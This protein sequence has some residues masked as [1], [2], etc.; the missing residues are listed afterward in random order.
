MK[1]QP[2][3][4]ITTAL[5]AAMT[6]IAVPQAAFAASAAEL[7][8]WRSAERSGDV[9]DYRAYLRQYPDGDFVDLARNRIDAAEAAA[10]TRAPA[11]QSSHSTDSAA[12]V[13]DDL[14]LTYKDKTRIQTELNALGYDT[15]G[16]D[17]IFGPGTRGSIRGWQS[18]IGQTPTGYLT[19]AQAD[20]LLDAADEREFT[21]SGQAD[22]AAQ[23]AARRGDRKVI[24][25]ER[26]ER[27]RA[28]ETALNLN[29]AQRTEVEQRLAM[30]GNQPGPVDGDFT[31]QTRLAIADFRERE[32]LERSR[33]LDRPMLARLVEKTDGKVGPT[34]AS[35]GSPI[36]PGVAAAIGL[37]ALAI[38]GAYLLTR[39]D[40]DEDDDRDRVGR[41]DVRQEREAERRRQRSLNATDKRN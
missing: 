36:D 5:V 19:E 6:A 31:R 40:D 37:G 30:A 33:F 7:T 14:S 24:R 23:V 38:G 20:G 10:S 41:G 2:R 25:A 28:D 39:D 18:K 16:V 12:D 11:Y 15:R 3:L 8:F 9:N 27:R 22:Y 32:G 1:R 17:G 29:E 21:S 34:G 4:T 35:S 13:E 26:R